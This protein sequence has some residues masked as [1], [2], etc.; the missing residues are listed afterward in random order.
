MLANGGLMNTMVGS[1]KIMKGEIM[2]LMNIRVFERKGFR[3][4]L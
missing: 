1:I 2:G 3:R 4:Q